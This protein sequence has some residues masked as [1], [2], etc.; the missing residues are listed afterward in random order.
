MQAEQDAEA[1]ARLATAQAATEAAHAEIST[2]SQ[3][4]LAASAAASESEAA[5][6]ELQSQLEAAESRAQL[7]EVQAQDAE[8]ARGNLEARAAEAE[9]RIKQ[10]EEDRLLE[11][12]AQQALLDKVP[13]MSLWDLNVLQKYQQSALKVLLISYCDCCTGHVAEGAAPARLCSHSAA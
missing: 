11:Q 9:A 10:L 2:L 1:G 12:E 4:L 5:L 6:A 13:T 8:S 3:D 7:A